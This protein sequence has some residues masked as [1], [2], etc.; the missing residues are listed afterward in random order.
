MVMFDDY[1]YIA[2]ICLSNTSLDVELSHKN[3]KTAEGWGRYE[4]AETIMLEF[5]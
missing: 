2:M 1:I 5:D 3:V 4:A